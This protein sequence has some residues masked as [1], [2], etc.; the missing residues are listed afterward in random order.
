MSLT[1]RKKGSPF[2][3]KSQE[4]FMPSHVD[5]ETEFV[6]CDSWKYLLKKDPRFE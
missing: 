3:K 1:P 2:Q 6:D 5:L 4:T